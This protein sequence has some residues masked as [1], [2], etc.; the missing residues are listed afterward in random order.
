MLMEQDQKWT[1]M[2]VNSLTR[3]RIVIHNSTKLHSMHTHHVMNII[4]RFKISA[5]IIIYSFTSYASFSFSFNGNTLQR[6]YFNTDLPWVLPV[7]KGALRCMHSHEPGGFIIYC[8]HV[9]YSWI[10]CRKLSQTLKLWDLLICSKQKALNGFKDM[11]DREFTGSFTE[12]YKG[13]RKN[14]QW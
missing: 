12:K 9:E 8:S 3:K 5:P 4:R 13:Y 2:S 14:F 7:R 1:L 10:D 6:M 11:C